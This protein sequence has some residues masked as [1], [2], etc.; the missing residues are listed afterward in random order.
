MPSRP[1][2]C[3]LTVPPLTGHLHPAL[4][5]A[6]GWEAAGHEAAWVGN[7]PVFRPL[8]GPGGRLFP[9]GSRLFRE[10]AGGGEAAV[11]SLWEGFV[12]PYSRFTLK[13]VERAVAEWRPDVVL[14][15]Q[16][17]PAG[18][19]A[20]HRAGVLWATFAPSA[21]EI[22]RPLRG[23]R[24]LERWLDGVLR[25][26]W[27]SARLP[28]Q[29]YLDPR[30]SPGLVLSTAS[31]AL[32]GGE[33]PP[34]YATVGPLLGGRTPA[35]FPWERL[36]GSRRRVLV[37]M[38]TLSAEVADGFHQRVARALEELAPDVQPVLA[39]AGGGPAP[40]GGIALDRVPVLE[41]LARGAVD[42]VLCHGGMNTVC[43]A[44]VHGVPLVLAPIRHDQP[45]VAERVAAAG[46]GVRVDFAGATSGQLR[47]ALRTVLDRPSHRA[48]ALMMGRQ[49]LHGGG[50][51]AAVGH[52]ERFTDGRNRSL[53]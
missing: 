21:M 34:P 28:E 2:R 13:A 14:V 23:E 40:A 47:D 29:E 33:L 7:E 1:L 6:G 22:G 51:E 53:R 10:Q 49:L 41:L 5:L 18:A 35:E 43:E 19:L 25:G 38:G 27:A 50:V 30:F 12:V 9:T 45:Y 42:A 39:R 8:L 24:E 36:D 44:L 20:A 52:L 15:D 48:A 32:L 46:A 11:R 16:H 4:A 17:S 37:T 26:L 3:L 31:P